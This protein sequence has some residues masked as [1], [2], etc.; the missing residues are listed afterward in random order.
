MT[1]SNPKSARPSANKHW[2]VPTR[3]MD[4]SHHC[5]RRTSPTSLRVCSVW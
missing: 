3:K 2:G 5:R 1:T 4:S